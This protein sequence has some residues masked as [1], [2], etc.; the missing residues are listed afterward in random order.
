MKIQNPKTQVPE[1]PQMSERDFLNDILSTEKHM[2]DSYAI[3][4]TEASHSQ[5]YQDIHS[6]YDETIDCQRDLFDLMFRKGW[7]S[8]DAA[9]AQ[10]LTQEHQQFQGY[11]NQFPYQPNQPLS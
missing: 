2:V 6:I 10:A 9:Q 8:F 11:S 4:M 5:L 3:A 7:Y 1:S